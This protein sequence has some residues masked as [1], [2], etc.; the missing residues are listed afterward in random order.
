MRAL[1][2]HSSAAPRTAPGILD[3]LRDEVLSGLLGIPKTLPAKLFYD[4]TGAALFERI[5]TLPEYY[6][7]RAELEILDARAGTIAALAGP[8]CALVEYGSGAGVC[9]HRT[10]WYR[11]LWHLRPERSDPRQQRCL[12]SDATSLVQMTDCAAAE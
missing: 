8:G 12:T 9:A 3:A 10:H 5:T 6:L 4:A 7:T 11:V 2:E 1:T